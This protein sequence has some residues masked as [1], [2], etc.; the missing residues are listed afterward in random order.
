MPKSEQ[1][2]LFDGAAP[3]PAGTGASALRPSASPSQTHAP[4]PTQR[5]A[6]RRPGDRWLEGDTPLP[7]IGFW[8]PAS[9][10]ERIGRTA[11]D[12]GLVVTSPSWVPRK[13][14]A[15]AV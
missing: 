13:P 4:G 10:R 5:P 9:R 15:E 11:R 14:V 7:T 1:L 12:D 8:L 3:S 6:A 2:S